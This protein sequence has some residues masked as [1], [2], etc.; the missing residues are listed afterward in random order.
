[1]DEEPS[2]SDA[3]P[4]QEIARKVELLG[5]AKAHADVLTLLVLA[6]LAGAFISLT[7]LPTC[8][9]SARARIGLRDRD[10]EFGVTAR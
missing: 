6:V 3:Y 9:A 5:V 8:E 7:G 10:R 1:M 4:P 2:L